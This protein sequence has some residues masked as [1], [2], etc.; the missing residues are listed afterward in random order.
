M[1]EDILL[2]LVQEMTAEKVGNENFLK[3][4]VVNLKIS[5]KAKFC[6]PQKQSKAFLFVLFLM[7]IPSSPL[8]IKIWVS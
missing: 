2:R 1:D 6:I 3:G 4:R 7:Q 8:S 5:S